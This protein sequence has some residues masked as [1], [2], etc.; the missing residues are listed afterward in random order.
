MLLYGDE[1]GRTQQGNNNVYCQDNPVSWFDWQQV[2]VD[3]LDFTQKLIA[4]VKE[5]RSFMRRHWF[6]GRHIHGKGVR[7][8]AW[9]RPDGTPMTDED[10]HSGFA[11]CL[12][13]F[14]NGRTVGVNTQGE[15]VVDDDF[16]LLFNAHHESLSVRLPPASYGARWERVFT[17]EELTFGE[18]SLELAAGEELVLEGRS[19]QVLKRVR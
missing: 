18:S 1:C 6:L 12:G 3:L 7:D 19:L 5:H 13:V 8:I 14:L 17:T 16:Y 9:L 10:W 4:F 2:D 15:A 11:K